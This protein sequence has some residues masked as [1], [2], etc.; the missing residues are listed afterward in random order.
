MIREKEAMKG[1]MERRLVY[2]GER[3]VQKM[4]AAYRI[5][6]T[7]KQMGRQ[8]GWRKNKENRPV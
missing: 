5:S 4:A 2:G 7:I 6:E 3:F 8:H 1:E